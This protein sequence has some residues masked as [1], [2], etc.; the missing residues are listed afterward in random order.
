MFAKLQ[1]A[2]NSFVVYVRVSQ[3]G[4]NRANFYEILYSSF[5]QR[6]VQEWVLDT[7]LYFNALPWN[8][9]DTALKIACK[10]LMNVT[11]IFTTTFHCTFRYLM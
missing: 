6:S 10:N 9:S 1:K 5:L 3:L 11:R 2:T 8:F 4:S 7:H